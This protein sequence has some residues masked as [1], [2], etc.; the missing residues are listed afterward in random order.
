MWRLPS[1]KTTLL[2]SLSERRL[3]AFIGLFVDDF[4]DS[5]S[6]KMT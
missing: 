2:K 6:D 4:A 5:V 3:E 1:S